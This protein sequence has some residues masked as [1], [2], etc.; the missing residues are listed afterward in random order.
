[1]KVDQYSDLR[2]SESA[3]SGVSCKHKLSQ[4]SE[5]LLNIDIIQQTPE[6][7]MKRK[8]VGA[9]LVHDLLRDTSQGEE[10]PQLSKKEKRQERITRKILQ[11]QYEDYYGV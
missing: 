11:D 1:M 4:D 7:I 5:L 10:K 8:Q 9:K 6:Q 2:P 3:H